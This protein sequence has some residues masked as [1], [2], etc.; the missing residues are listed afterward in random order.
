MPHSLRGGCRSACQGNN[1]NNNQ[2]R[3]RR[4]RQAALAY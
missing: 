1:N 2:L 3:R 4:R